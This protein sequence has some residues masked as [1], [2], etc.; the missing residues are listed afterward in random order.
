MVFV[1]V[2]V[3]VDCTVLTGNT[4][5]EGNIVCLRDGLIDTD[6]IFVLSGDGWSVGADVTILPLIFSQ[7][8]YNFT[9]SLFT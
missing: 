2:G 5:T 4:V 8:A 9:S 3:F 6:G 1:T 7:T